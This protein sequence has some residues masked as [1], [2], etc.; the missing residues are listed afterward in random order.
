MDLS[1]GD[2]NVEADIILAHSLLRFMP[3]ERHGQ[4]M[5]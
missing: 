2:L 4:T 5:E 1:G 3:V